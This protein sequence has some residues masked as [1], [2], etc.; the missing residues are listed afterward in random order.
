MP[1]L[2]RG[3]RRPGHHRET[4]CRDHVTLDAAVAKAVRG[5][6]HPA[7]PRVRM[8]RHVP[9]DSPSCTRAPGP[10][11]A[12]MRVDLLGP[13]RTTAQSRATEFTHFADGAAA[14]AFGG[15]ASG[16]RTSSETATV[17]G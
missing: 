9:C 6:T 11:D 2:S 10:T 13:D 17:V 8:R 15:V 14:C 1:S 5:S 3:C 4:T 12:T 16:V 7:I